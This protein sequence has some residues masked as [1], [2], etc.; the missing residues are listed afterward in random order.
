MVNQNKDFLTNQ[1]IQSHKGAV[2]YCNLIY[3]ITCSNNNKAEIISADK[4]AHLCPINLG[5]N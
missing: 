1:R 2:S 3:N 5:V 4:A